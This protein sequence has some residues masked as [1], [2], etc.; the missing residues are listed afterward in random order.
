[1]LLKAKPKT[2][3][4]ISS[5]ASICGDF[6]SHCWLGR[7]I[8]YQRNANEGENQLSIVA[9]YKRWALESGYLVKSTPNVTIHFIR[10]SMVHDGSMNV[11][12]LAMD[13]A[14]NARTT[15]SLQLNKPIYAGFPL[16]IQVCRCWF[17]TFFSDTKK[18]FSFCEQPRNTC[19]KC[20]ADAKIEVKSKKS[21]EMRSFV[22]QR[23]KEAADIRS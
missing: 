22:P 2:Y 16:I 18:K 14:Q 19:L 5:K 23:T 7:M 17:R 13:L 15:L 21:S 4:R 3:S 20:F 6:N 12:D 1:M 9:E 10:S 8:N 11:S